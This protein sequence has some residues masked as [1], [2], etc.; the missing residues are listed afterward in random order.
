[1]HPDA[2]KT[3][4]SLNP[5]EHGHHGALVHHG[6]HGYP[7]PAGKDHSIM[8]VTCKVAVSCRVGQ[9]PGMGDPYLD[10]TYRWWHLPGPSP[11]LLAAAEDGWLGPAG[12]A[13]DL[14]CG[15]GTEASFLAASGW[16]VIGVDLSAAAVRAASASP[17]GVTFLQADALALPLRDG[18]ADLL[19]DRGCFHYVDAADRIRYAR[20]AERVLRRGGQFVLRACRSAAAVPNDIGPAVIESVFRDWRIDQLSTEDIPS[21]TR[22]MP[23]IVVRLHRR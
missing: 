22:S 19:I 18:R 10:G 5:P 3:P 1:V 8:A 14:G 7:L 20:E 6:N 16:A 9:Y 12:I 13:V 11:E 23:A 15:L 17:A 4:Q 2:Q 21:G